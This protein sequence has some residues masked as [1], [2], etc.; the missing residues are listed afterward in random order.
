MWNIDLLKKKKNS[1]V[2]KYSSTM[3]ASG[4]DVP[5]FRSCGFPVKIVPKKTLSI[6]L[7][8]VFDDEGDQA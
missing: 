5:I 1:F 2:G 4:M 6:E 3:V 7:F 8:A